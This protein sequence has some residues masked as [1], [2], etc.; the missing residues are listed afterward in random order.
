MIV[1][2]GVDS[3]PFRMDEYREKELIQCAS[4]A[5]ARA[6]ISGLAQRSD[7]EIDFIRIGAVKGESWETNPFDFVDY[8]A[9]FQRETGRRIRVRNSWPDPDVRHD[10]EEYA[11]RQGLTLIF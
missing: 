4:F 6:V 7:I 1:I 3:F 9:V 10:L 2:I 11:G 5:A 8:L